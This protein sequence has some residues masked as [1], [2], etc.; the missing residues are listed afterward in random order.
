MKHLCKRAVSLALACAILL[1]LVLVPGALQAQA[2]TG[3]DAGYA[4]GRGGDGQIYAWGVDV[5]EHQGVGFN[6]QNLKNN[7]YT[8]V[9]P[10]AGF[11]SRKD[12]RFEEYYRAAKAAGLNVGVYFYSYATTVAEASYEADRCLSYIAGKKFEYPVY[13]DFED[14]SAR[15]GN[16]TLARNMCW[17]FLDKIAAAGYLAGLYGYAGWM[18]ENYGGWVPTAQICQKY[19]CWL[20]NYYDSN[21]NYWNNIYSRRYGMYQ[22]T[23]SRY[24]GGVGPL[25][26]NKCYKDYP[27][28]VKKYGFNGYSAESSVANITDGT[29]TIGMHDDNTYKVDLADY[30]VTDGAR[31]QVWQQNYADNQKFV[32][33]KDGADTYTIRNVHSGKYLEILYGGSNGEYKVTQCHYTGADCQRWYL[34]QLS[35]GSFSLKNKGTGKYMDVANGSISNGNDIQTW[36]GN[37]TAAQKFWLNP[38]AT[39]TDGVYTVRCAG[40]STYGWD[41][42]GASSDS[43]AN[44]QAW[45]SQHKFVISHGEDGLY[46]IRVLH[47][48]KYLDVYDAGKNNGTNITQYDFHGNANQKWSAIPNTDGTYSFVSKCNG[49]YI[50]LNGGTLANGSNLQCWAGNGTNAQKWTLQR[51][52]VLDSGVFFIGNAAQPNYRLEVSNRS[53]ENGANVL[54]YH[55]HGATSQQFRVEKQDD[56][57]YTIT[58][59]NSGKAL[60]LAGN[61]KAPSTNI[62]QSETAE[63][64][65]VVP[66]SDGSYTFV[67]ASN[68]LALDMNGNNVANGSNIQC[69]TPNGGTAQKWVLHKTVTA[70]IA[71]GI[72]QINYGADASFRADVSG[73]S[74]D[75]GATIHLWTAHNGENQKY[76]LTHVGGGFY[77]IRSM[78]SG[79]Y[80]DVKN[81]AAEKGTDLQ[82]YQGNGSTSQKF[83]LLTNR[84]DSYSLIADNSGLAVDLEDGV[85]ENGRNIRLWSFNGSA[86]QKWSFTETTHTHN[87]HETVVKYTK[88]TEGYTLCECGCGLQYK[89]DVVPADSTAPVISNVKVD[90]ISAGGF[91]VS[92]DVTDDHAVAR[93]QFPTWTDNNGQ[94]DL[95]WHEASV[96][97]GKA[98][99]YV[100]SAEHK[101]EFGGYT[102][103]IYAYDEVGNMACKGDTYA[104]VP[105]RDTKTPMTGNLPTGI[106][107]IGNA[108]NRNF[109]LDVAAQSESNGANI[110]TWIH[111][112]GESQMWVIT[113]LNNGY[114]NIRNLKTGKYLD[115]LGSKTAQGTNVDQW[116]GGDY[117][118]QLWR[119][120]VNGNGTYTFVNKCN[121]LALDM[122]GGGAPAN[123]TN[124][125]VWGRNASS[126]QQWVLVPQT[127]LP[128]GTYKM[129]NCVN[130]N[131]M[132]EVTSSRMDNGANVQI[133]QNYNGAAQNWILTAGKDGLYTITNQNSGKVMDVEDGSSQNGT[134]I[135]QY[136]A[137]GTNAQ[138]WLAVRN[139]DGTYTFIS[140]GSGKALDMNGGG[141]PDN[142]KNIQLWVYNGSTAQKWN[143]MKQ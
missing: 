67:S 119:V 112:G 92:C 68:G 107:T 41:I 110:H 102:V 3:Y 129:G 48:G 7:G 66:N 140:R 113:N 127:V 51:Q 39:L 40:D 109:L 100:K 116:A 36:A 70:P 114:Y 31:A 71:D 46:T 19:E 52:G 28:I 104:V 143:M 23:S 22:F 45:N 27:S 12:Y 123:G 90:Q 1:G 38:A 62:Q 69:W 75:N 135:S 63:K 4:G 103:H 50:D 134:N 10:R 59:V 118:N 80:W 60:S 94:D 117:D 130:A 54:L 61:G 121:G 139:P 122:N 96:K 138:K 29:Y 126:A 115:V 106:Y 13:F 87:Y 25:D 132:I 108:A 55:A 88:T 18:D 24:I 128:S 53:T 79:K 91:R 26:T 64:W 5:S 57:L 74:L 20:A 86:A 2:A 44:L 83:L 89:K 72:Y 14:G 142:G 124:V 137:N 120:V 42:A 81:G 16:G 125:Q 9:I 105:A 43:G 37:G 65:S 33:Q 82:Q 76:Q 111:H 133:W 21:G 35:D 34:Y 56:A 78:N 6:F 97:N 73:N 8:Y 93:V 131:Q 101:N 49:L 32:F 77:T 141:S 47:S 99:F 17:A 84:D 95:V 58:N 15:S 136:T 98:T 30:A 11:V 85:A